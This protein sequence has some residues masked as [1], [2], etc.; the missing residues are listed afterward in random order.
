M[1]TRDDIDVFVP[2]SYTFRCPATKTIEKTLDTFRERLGFYFHAHIVCD[3]I[4]DDDK[5]HSS[6]YEDFIDA[7]SSRL[8]NVTVHV[9]P[10]WK[11]LIG[12]LK[13]FC[14][15]LWQKPLI[16][17]LQHDWKA[18]KQIDFDC[19]LSA[20]SDDVQYIRFH[21]RVI[22]TFTWSMK[23][24]EPV[25]K[26]G[27]RLSKNG[28]WCDVP[29]FATRQHYEYHIIP[30]LS[31]IY[32]GNGGQRGVEQRISTRY[33]QHIKKYGW[34]NA[35]RRWGVYVYGWPGDK[36]VI[37]HIGWNVTAERHKRYKK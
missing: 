20:L 29:H 26:F 10:S 4:A 37:R 3:G 11:G 14:D 19:I 36:P 22:N 27:C 13:Y 33:R 25:E 31:I 34:Q 23:H 21:K 2:T 15:Q 32:K 5:N 16:F 18:I 35:H 28:A 12:S 17:N 8:W 1:F 7:L 24:V 9:M 30:R 6:E